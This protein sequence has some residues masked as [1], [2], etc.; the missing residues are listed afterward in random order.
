MSRKTSAPSRQGKAPPRTNKD[1]LKKL[2]QFRPSPSFDIHNADVETGSFSAF[3]PERLKE[4]KNLLTEHIQLHVRVVDWSGE[5]TGLE[6]FLREAVNAI[7][8]YINHRGVEPAFDRN[9]AKILLTRANEAVCVAQAQL[10]AIAAWPELATFLERLFV[11]TGKETSS[12]SRH[13]R[14]QVSESSSKA[15]NQMKRKTLGILDP[16]SLAILLLQVEPLLTLAAERVEFQLG[17]FQRDDAAR[18]FVDAMAF[19]W[20][21]G[22]AR[23][24]TYS[25]PSTRSRKPSPFAELIAAVNERIFSSGIRS[26]NNF[27][28]YG[29]GSVKRMK[30][31]HP[32][33]VKRRV[34]RA[35]S[36]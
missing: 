26:P 33:L 22:T 30:D 3:P 17:D 14:K 12:T 2:P 29:Q 32:E 20:I 21:C 6:R 34:S 9:R 27:R 23:L 35:F 8:I 28:E 25:S 16:K 1:A 24:P 31:E 36:G 4:I 7:A 19:A 13:M 15:S 5:P 18:E 10:Q 11:G